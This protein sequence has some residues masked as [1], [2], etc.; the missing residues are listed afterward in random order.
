[1][2]GRKNGPANDSMLAPPCRAGG[3]TP[4]EHPM[5]C[6]D[7]GAAGAAQGSARRAGRA[8]TQALRVVVRQT[9][10]GRLGRRRRMERR[11]GA[12]RVRPRRVHNVLRPRGGPRAG[13]HGHR[14]TKAYELHDGGS[15][16]PALGLSGGGLIACTWRCAPQLCSD[17]RRVSKRLL[18]HLCGVGREGCAQGG[19]VAHTLPAARVEQS[20]AARG[21][22]CR[23]G[24]A[25]PRLQR[26]ARSEAQSLSRRAAK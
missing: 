18:P 8:R 10:G 12:G 21:A 17:C 25:R 14:D 4:P 15:L 11:R 2:T 5:P 19:R 3:R 26:A 22:R 20:A 9:L 24:A 7:G 23:Q 16:T 1:M 13:R 6:L